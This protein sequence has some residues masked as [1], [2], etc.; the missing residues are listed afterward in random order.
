MPTVE[1][2]KFDNGQAEDIRTDRIGQC[3]QSL[4]FDT[5]SNPHKLIPYPDS[6]LETVENL[7]PNPYALGEVAISGLVANNPF[8]TVGYKDRNGNNFRAQYM[9][10]ALPTDTWTKTGYGAGASGESLILGSLI[11]YNDKPY[12]LAYIYTGGAGEYRLQKLASSGSLSTVGTTT[13]SSGSTTVFPAVKPVIHPE[14]DVLYGAHGYRMW[15]WNDS[16]YNTFTTAVPTN[17]AVRA[18][19]PYGAYLAVGVSPLLG[20]GKSTVYLWGRDVTI[21]T[22][23]GNIDA[24]EGVIKHMQLLNNNLV[25]IMTSSNYL[26]TTKQAK[27]YIKIYSG[28]E[29]ITVKEFNIAS[30]DINFTYF[31]SKNGD[32]LYFY[33]DNDSAIYVVGRNK[34]GEYVMVQDRYVLNGTTVSNGWGLSIIGDTLFAGVNDNGNYKFTRTTIGANVVYS[35]TS[36]YKTTINPQM[37]INDRLENKQLQAV[38]ISF[39]GKTGGNIKLKYSIDGSSF[40]TIIDYNTTAIEEVVDA[41]NDNLGDALLT[42]KEIQFQIESTGGVEPTSIEYGYIVLNSIMQ[43]S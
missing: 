7:S 28:G 32:K 27:L 1:L 42:G 33:A 17:M 2:R 12:N 38:R 4:N 22:F 29:M 35:A 6:V 5:L 11:V 34:E 25:V 3:E 41:N 37:V 40:A 24:G 20:V 9:F 36:I 43:K 21:N 23:Q 10:K 18:L 15:L 19:S 30:T 13:D 14:D 26:S 39:I 16:A 8:V 31:N